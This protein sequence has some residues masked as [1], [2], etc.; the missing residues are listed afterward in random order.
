MLEIAADA[1]HEDNLADIGFLRHY[2]NSEQSI[3][4]F[5][6]MADGTRMACFARMAV[7]EYKAGDSIVKKGTKGD[8][9]YF[10]EDGKAAAVHNGR[11]LRSFAEA[12]VFGEIAFAACI[13]QA[14]GLGNVEPEHMLRVCN[15]VASTTCVCWELGLQC[16]VEVSSRARVVLVRNRA[17]VTK[18]FL[19]RQPR[20][21]AE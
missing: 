15:V 8:T 17:P 19:H 5:D 14:L 13:K 6:S 21:T 11:T 12:S 7:R 10:V 1:A 3:E 4:L 20:G 18:L 2:A 9:L 16:F